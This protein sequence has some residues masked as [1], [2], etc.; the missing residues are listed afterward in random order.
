M[1]EYHFND[2]KKIN[3]FIQIFVNNGFKHHIDHANQSLI[4]F[5]K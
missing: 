1:V 5:W 3:K 4:S 2:M